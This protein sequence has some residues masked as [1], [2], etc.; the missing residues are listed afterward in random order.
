MTVNKELLQEAEEKLNSF[1]N[2]LKDE[3]EI[4]LFEKIKED[5]KKVFVSSDFIYKNF[6]KNPHNLKWAKRFCNF[7]NKI[8][9]FNYGKALSCM[10]SDSESEESFAKKIRIFRIKETV[11]IGFA[12]II[13]RFDL[14]KTIKRLSALADVIIEKTVDFLYLRYCLIYGVPQSESSRRQFPVV[15]GMGKLGGKELNFSSDIDLIFAYHKDGR[16]NGEEKFVTNREFFTKLFTKLIEILDNFTDDGFVFRVDMRLRPYGENGPIVMSFDATEDYYQTEGREW[17]R[18]AFIKARVCAGDKKAGTKLLK[19]LYPFIYRKYLDYGTIESLRGM[20][21]KIDAQAAKKGF[22]NNIKLG[23]GGIREIEF[24]GQI[25]QLI[26]GGIDADLQKRDICAILRL[27]EQKEYITKEAANSLVCAYIFLRNTEHRLQEFADARAHSI[28]TEDM[29]LTRLA[30]SLN[31][32][33]TSDFL[34]ALNK[35]RKNVRFY[36]STLLFPEKKDTSK[37]DNLV[38]KELKYLWEKLEDGQESFNILKKVGYEKPDEIY[39]LLKGL[40]KDIFSEAVSV[41]GKAR[42]IKLIPALLIEASDLAEPDITLKRI[43]LLIKIIIKRTCYLSLFLENPNA[44]KQLIKLADAS[45]WI[46]SLLTKHPLLLDEL[47]DHRTLY[48]PPRK[49][50]FKKELNFRISRFAPDD[51]ESQ[52]DEARIFQQANMLRVAAAEVTNII[53]VKEASYK[54]CE[55][56]DTL[57]EKVLDVLWKQLTAKY[58]APSCVMD[59][60]ICDK[61]FVVIAY[62]KLGG[63]ELSYGSDLDMVF[64]HSGEK[65]QTFGDNS[66]FFSRLGQRTLHFLSSRTSA[67]ILYETD[68]RLRPSGASGLLVSHIDSFKEY[69][70]NQAWTWEHQALVRARPVTGNLILFEKFNLIRKEIL[71]KKRDKEKLTKDIIGMRER[72]REETIYKK[73]DVFDLKQGFGGIVDIEFLI[74]YLVLLHAFF[75]PNLLEDTNNIKFIQR[76]EK[77]GILSSD[78]A[79]TLK[80][81]YTAYRAAIHRLNFA[82]KKGLVNAGD[83]KTMRKEIIKIWEHFLVPV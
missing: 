53:S 1:K 74:Q 48:A 45:S 72:I 58:G 81:G 6:L 19:R 17:E 38:E 77:I 15:L 82:E 11:K 51:I 70:E 4:F 7:D 57:L 54:L 65:E 75:Y 27:L 26:R 20:K 28:P 33:D 62:G 55:I 40:K 21:D 47:I 71:S 25:F 16:T 30:Y 34:S 2:L 39:K 22:E 50:D 5:L 12:D 59:E 64:L 63:E 3:K 46:I 44:L 31:F 66:A 73:Q 56:A 37:N 79:K 36:F 68:M 10:L 52:M 42:L 35:H 24:F 29:R 76:F 60:K 41:K 83:F 78:H 8:D 43:F 49:A 13:G 9:F 32:S 23:K 14:F 18:Y 61:G 69:Q 67:G 80:K